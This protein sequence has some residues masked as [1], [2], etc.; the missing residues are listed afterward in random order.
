VLAKLELIGDN[1]G[2]LYQAD[3]QAARRA[4]EKKS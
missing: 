2:A 4:E 1:R 3:Q